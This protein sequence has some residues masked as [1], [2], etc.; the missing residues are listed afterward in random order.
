MVKVLAA[1]M[2]QL[3]GKG[4]ERVQHICLGRNLVS[5]FKQQKHKDIV[6]TFLK[7]SRKPCKIMRFDM[8]L[9]KTSLSSLVHT[10]NPF[11]SSLRRSEEQ[12]GFKT[13]VY[14]ASR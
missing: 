10:A 3:M 2:R 12:N 9:P 14:Q 7:A 4:E 6:F 11:I 8:V 1:L 13:H 5:R